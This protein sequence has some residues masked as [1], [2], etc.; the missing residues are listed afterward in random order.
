MINL[1]PGGVD[2]GGIFISA[3]SLLT[4]A[5]VSWRSKIFVVSNGT[6]ANAALKLDLDGM[7]FPLDKAGSIGGF[8]PSNSLYIKTT[9]T[10][11]VELWSL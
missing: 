2:T 3:Q 7:A 11:A 1:T 4:L 9:I 5:G 6:D 10:G 8:P